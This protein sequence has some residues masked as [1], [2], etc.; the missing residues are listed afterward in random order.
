MRLA[1]EPHTRL[2][3]HCSPYHTDSALWPV[4]HQLSRAAGFAAR[5]STDAKLDKLEALLAR[6]DENRPTRYP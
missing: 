1:D 5:D 6:G 3:Y 2:R 4:I